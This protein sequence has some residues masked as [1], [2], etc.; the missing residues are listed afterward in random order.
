[1]RAAERLGEDT[2]ALHAPWLWSPR[3]CRWW[4]TREALASSSGGGGEG[5]R[6]VHTVAAPEILSAALGVP[7]AVAAMFCGYL[8]ARG[9]VRGK[10]ECV[11]AH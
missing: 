5:G 3:G 6:N 7:S 9:L 8:C 4:P 1:V 10:D 11:L 2:E